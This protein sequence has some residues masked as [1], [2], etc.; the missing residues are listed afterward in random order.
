M[1]R[2]NGTI[3]EA[4]TVGKGYRKF[5]NFISTVLFSA[6]IEPLPTTFTVEPKI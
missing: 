4:N 2:L 1:E 5:E 3:Q 6:A